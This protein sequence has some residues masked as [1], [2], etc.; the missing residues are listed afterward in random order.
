MTFNLQ[1]LIRSSLQFRSLAHATQTHNRHQKKKHNN[2]IFFFRLGRTKHTQLHRSEKKK[3]VA[4]FTPYTNTCE[5]STGYHN[6]NNVDDDDGSDDGSHS[7]SD[8][9]NNIS[10][11]A[12]LRA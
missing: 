7:G 3:C 2:N 11:N 1:T 4:H 8:G 9:I 6:N 12:V 5:R 10:S